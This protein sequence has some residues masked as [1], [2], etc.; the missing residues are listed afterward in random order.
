MQLQWVLKYLI[1]VAFF[2][3]VVKSAEIKGVDNAELLSLIKSQI[4]DWKNFSE[5]AIAN[6][7][8][9]RKDEEVIKK[10]ADSFGYFDSEVTSTIK[11]HKVTFSV[12]LNER[13]RFNDVLL[14]YTDQ[15]DYKYGLKVKQVFDLIN[16]NYDS[17]TDSKQ[18]ADG[19]ERIEDF[20]KKQGFA[21][22][23]AERPIIEFD[24]ESKKI[25][26]TYNVALSGKT[27]I[28]GTILN[29]KTKKNPKLIESFVKNRIPWKDGD[30]YNLQKIEDLKD[31]LMTSGIFSAIDV[32]LSPPVPDSKDSK[33]CRAII[34]ISVEEGKLREIEIGGRY[35]SSEK[36]GVLFSWAHYN[37]DGK[38]SKLSAVAD[39]A[40]LEKNVKLKYDMY[41]LFYKEQNLANKVFYK[42][43]NVDAY[44]VSTVGAESVLWQ[45]FGKS[46][47]IGAGG[48]YENSKTKDKL[49]AKSKKVNFKAFGIPIGINFDTTDSYLDPQKGIR[50]LGMATPY[51]GKPSNVTIV[52]GKASLYIPIRKNAFKNAMVISMYTKIGSILRDKKRIMPRDKFFFAGGNNSVRGYGYQM[53]GEFNNKKKPYGGESLFEIG[54]EPRLRVSDDVGLVAFFEGGNVYSSNVPKPFKKM[55]FGYG[56]GVRY[57]TSI[58]PIRLDIAFPTK[59]RKTK[60]G[61]RVDSR[62]NLYISVGQAF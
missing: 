19:R 5:E 30:V 42:K 25:K 22:V 49:K 17:Y 38:G 13:Y 43:E 62:F 52:T 58:A 57:Y 55:L 4:S 16:I 35:G 48:R 11:N 46:F 34:T 45:S 59:L 10:L 56:G 15:R 7:F 41:D 36:I 18:I 28:D 47:K 53:L 20:L 39:I 32:A 24:R 51:F 21:F 37:I 27:I 6:K 44:N 14:I 31:K 29:I 40:K 12:K 33:V 61:K 50:C 1:A 9:L 2:S 54:V 23:R 26:V 3:I 60:K 8:R